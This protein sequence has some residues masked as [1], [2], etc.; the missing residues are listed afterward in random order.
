MAK[1]YHVTGARRDSGLEGAW[2]IVAED[3]EEAADIAN[4]FGVLVANVIEL[5]DVEG[6]ALPA[7]EVIYDAK[8][9]PTPAAI[10]QRF[11]RN[12]RATALAVGII[13]LTFF[14]AFPCWKCM[15]ADATGGTKVIYTIRPWFWMPD[16]KVFDL[17]VGKYVPVLQR[18][19]WLEMWYFVGVLVTGA[20]A[21]MYFF[22]PSS[23]EH[24]PTR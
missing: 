18:R 6:P 11:R 8:V 4:R 13:I 1:R 3:A 23:R 14:S 16:E 2:A 12:P 21:A 5:R 17:A 20:T 10:R 15:V 7:M 9:V 19:L 22:L 24:K